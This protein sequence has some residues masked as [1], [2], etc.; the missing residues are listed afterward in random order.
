[1]RPK[2]WIE[3]SNESSLAKYGEVLSWN[4]HQKIYE[5][6]SPSVASSMLHLIRFK[7]GD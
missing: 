7:K 1:M 5:P 3:G 2:T 6:E 4:K